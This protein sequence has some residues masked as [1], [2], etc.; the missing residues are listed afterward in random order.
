MVFNC[1][2]H[3]CIK[4]NATCLP[5]HF[6]VT[7]SSSSIFSLS[8][9]GLYEILYTNLSGILIEIQEIYLK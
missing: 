9:Y 5:I 4:K 8:Q 2:L 6:Y 7:M 3:T 1:Q